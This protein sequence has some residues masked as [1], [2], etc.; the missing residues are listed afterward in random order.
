MIHAFGRPDPPVPRLLAS[1][2]ERGH[3]L[4]G[5][6]EGATDDSATLVIA[7]GTGADPLA[8]AAL[9][10]GWRRARGGRVMVVSSLG[11]HPDAKARRLRELWELEEGARRA[12]L[13]L[14]VLRLAPLVG[15]RSPLWLR[16]RSRPRLPSGGRQ[17][18]NPVAEDD[19]VDSIEKAILGHAEWTGWYELAGPQVVSLAEMVELAAASGPVL[20]AHAGAWEPP[21]S[22]LL[23]HRIAEP[24]PWL[25]HFDLSPRPLA[26]YVAAGM[27]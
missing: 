9:Y 19:V 27:P 1:L 17:L 2:A 6:S 11:A 24:D 4:G 10:D 12:G 16:L 22:E 13:P 26:A 14:L 20:P 23:E 25:V 21:W 18:L 7:V 15:P 5:P 8:F 3:R